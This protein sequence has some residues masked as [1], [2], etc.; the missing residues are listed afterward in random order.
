MGLERLLHVAQPLVELLGLGLDLRRLHKA[1]GD[2]TLRVALAHGR[3]LPDPLVH[4]GLRVGRLVALV[5]TVAAVA[6]DVDHHVAVELVAVHHRESHRRQA[7]LRV[8]RVH[9]DDRHVEPLGEI[10]RVVR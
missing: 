10:A 6:D 4:Q 5:V 3:R 2:E 7:C 9:V 1:G 8:V